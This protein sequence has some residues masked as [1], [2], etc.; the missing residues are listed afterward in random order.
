MPMSNYNNS[1][2]IYFQNSLIEFLHVILINDQERWLFHLKLKILDFVKN[3]LARINLCFCPPESFCPFSQYY[4]HI[5]LV[6]F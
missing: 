4:N 5:D 1:R 6:M 3:A 2:I